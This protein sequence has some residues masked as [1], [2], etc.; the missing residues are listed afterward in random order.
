MRGTPG[1]ATLIGRVPVGD[2]AG[3]N[4]PAALR[5]SP[6]ERLLAATGRGQ[7]VL[8]LFSIGENGMLARLTEVSSG[9]DWPRDVQFTPDGRF[10]VCCNERSNR[11]TV[12]ALSEGRLEQIDALELTAPTNV[13]FRRT[14]E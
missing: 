4:Y 10:L 9:G 5:L 12:F 2:G 6:D 3:E 13:I 1:S 11:V 7:N 14:E 8:S